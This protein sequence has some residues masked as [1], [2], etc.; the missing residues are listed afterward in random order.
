MTNCKIASGANCLLSVLSGEADEGLIPERLQT[1]GGEMLQRSEAPITDLY[2]PITAVISVVGH[3]SSGQTAELGVIGNECAAGLI[4]LMGAESAT[5]EKTVQVGGE[6][7]RVPL[8]SAQREF[9]KGGEFQ[10]AVHSCT[11]RFTQQVAQTLLCNRWHPVEQ[12]LIRWLL[13]RHDRIKGDVIALTHEYIAHMLGA[14]RSTITQT[15]K[16]LQ[17]AGYIKYAWGRVTIIDRE[18]LENNTCE[19]YGIIQKK[20]QEN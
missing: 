16:R 20:Y 2:F 17:E 15:A 10:R 5:Y 19:C 8:Y 6:V 12:R 14:N 3:M 18:G 1:T 11:Q 9:D 7:V 4:A 13:M